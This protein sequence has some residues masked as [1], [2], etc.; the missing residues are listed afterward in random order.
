MP[1]VRDLLRMAQLVRILLLLAASR[2]EKHLKAWQVSIDGDVKGGFVAE[3]W[4]SNR[5][6]QTEP[7][8]SHAVETGITI[9]GNN[10]CFAISDYVWGHQWRELSYRHFQLTNKMLSFTVDLSGVS[11]ARK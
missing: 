1:A 11:C 7:F 2:A 3:E 4:G 10:R 5:I 8:D 6:V 9:T